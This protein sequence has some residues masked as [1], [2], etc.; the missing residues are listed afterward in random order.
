MEKKNEMITESIYRRD[1]N[2]IYL[3]HTPLLEISRDYDDRN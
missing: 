3:L 1:I 2:I